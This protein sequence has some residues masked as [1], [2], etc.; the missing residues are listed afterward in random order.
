MNNKG[1][2][3][4]GPNKKRVWQGDSSCISNTRIGWGGGGHFRPQN[5]LHHYY[6]L[7]TESDTGNFNLGK[8]FPD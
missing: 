2:G 4:P 6:G 8:R 1:P 5:S 3:E 7:L